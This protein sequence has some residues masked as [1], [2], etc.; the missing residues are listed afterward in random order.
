MCHGGRRE[1]CCREADGKRQVGSPR[2]RWEE[3]IKLGFK[4]N[5]VSEDGTASACR[6]DVSHSALYTQFGSCSLSHCHE[7]CCQ[8]SGHSWPPRNK[9]ADTMHTGR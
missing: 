3:N 1:G 7:Q 2:L 4:R 6:A 5:E 9:I 8:Y